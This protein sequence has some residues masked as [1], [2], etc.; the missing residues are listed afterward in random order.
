MDSPRSHGGGWRRGARLLAILRGLSPPAGSA[1]DASAAIPVMGL[2]GRF[3]AGRVR[4]GPALRRRWQEP[5]PPRPVR[6]HSRRPGRRG[7]ERVPL[8]DA[9]LPCGGRHRGSSTDTCADRNDAGARHNLGA[10]RWPR[11]TGPPSYATPGHRRLSQA[12]P[13]GPAPLP[14]R[15]TGRP[16][17]PDA[18]ARISRSPTTSVP[19][20]RRGP[21]CVPELQHL[22]RAAGDPREYFKAIRNV[23]APGLD[24]LN[25][26][27]LVSPPDR[28]APSTKWR[29][30]YSGT[31]GRVFENTHVWP[32]VFTR[33][34][35]NGD[36]GIGSLSVSEYREIA[37]SITFT[38]RVRGVTPV[39][40]E[41]SIVTD[42]GWHARLDLGTNLRVGKVEGTFLSIIIPAGTHQVHLDYRPP[43]L[44]AGM[45]LSATV[46][47]LLPAA[48]YALRRK[49]RLN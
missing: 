12:G 43:G 27:Y 49:Q 37:N 42:G 41:T 5:A 4:A 29:L 22:P 19:R 24:R 14:L 38:A 33:A 34:P 21:I 31:D 39:L 1:A 48:A 6:T 44:T 47:I 8:L 10:R 7:S 23:E 17:S 18:A 26:K 45:T 15:V 32:R 9:A 13:P 2:G 35:R 46:A 16:L 3:R 28:I 25:V 40:A 30:V 11:R 20:A 36:V